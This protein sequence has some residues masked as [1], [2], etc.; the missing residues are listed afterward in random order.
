MTYKI[1]E[2]LKLQGR[3]GSVTDVKGIQSSASSEEVKVE[4]PAPKEIKAYLDRFVVGQEYAK[5]V[6]STLLVSHMHRAEYNESVEKHTDMLKKSNLL[7]IGGSGVGKTLCMKVAS[8]FVDVPMVIADATKLTQEGYVGSS[9]DTLLT[10]LYIASGKDVKKAA[11]G[12][13][14]LDEFD[15]LGAQRG[16]RA[17]VSTGAVQQSLL[18]MVE[19]GEFSIATER[20]E[21]SRVP[22]VKLDTSSITF[23]FAGAF[24]GMADNIKNNVSLGFLE[25][26]KERH[27]V[28]SDIINFGILPEI[29][30]RIGTYITLHELSAAD[31]FKVLVDIESSIVSQYKKLAE[32]HGVKWKLGKKDYKAIIERVK[33]TKLGARGLQREVEQLTLPDFYKGGKKT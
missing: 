12:I 32:L 3:D 13:I 29:L 11:K 24:D 27:I 10:D 1:T 9:V 21:S 20:G 17:A 28:E 14:F 8:E 22:R 2:I 33:G 19:G 18:R 25:S 7:L 23:V 15:K 6:I 26:A 30:G 5:K 31:M 16:E 4:I